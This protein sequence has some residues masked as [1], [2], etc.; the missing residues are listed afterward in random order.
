LEHRQINLAN[1]A[2]K[3]SKAFN[4]K[5][6]KTLGGLADFVLANPL[7]VKNIVNSAMEITE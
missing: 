2:T 4:A 7:D 1:S 3:I 5:S 6:D